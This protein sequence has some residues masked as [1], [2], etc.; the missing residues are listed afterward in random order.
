MINRKASVLAIAASVGGAN[1]ASAQDRQTAQAAAMQ[2][3]AQGAAATVDAFHRALASGNVSG[4][5]AYL[6]EDAIVFESGGIER[7]KKEYAAHHAAADAE[8]AKAVPSRTVRRSGQASGDFGWILTE[9]R[10]T[11]SFKGK[12]VDRV[13]TETMLLRRTGTTWRI[14]HV[15]WSS[16]SSKS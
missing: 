5:L 11:G 3:A 16:A 15:H 2:P 7:G 1:L 12:H 13:T 10:T 9:G 14:V 8:F 4:A 6:S